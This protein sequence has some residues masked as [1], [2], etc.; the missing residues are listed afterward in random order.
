MKRRP[1]F[2]LLAASALFTIPA[3]SATR[4]FLCGFTG[5]DYVVQAVPGGPGIPTPF[6]ALGDEYCAVGFVT[7]MSPLLA[8]VTNAGDEHTFHLAEAMTS[9]I[10][11]DGQ[12]LEVVF[13]PHARFRIYED[14]VHNAAYGTNPP[15]PSAPPTFVDGTLVLGADITNLVLV[16]DYTQSQGNFDCS[17]SLDEGSQLGALVPAQRSGWVM[18]GT[19]GRPNATIPEG[20]VNQL[21]GEVQIPYVVPAAQRSWGSIKS[22]YR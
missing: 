5:F 13:A 4:E 9:S 16:Y 14:A 17:A 3:Q 1:L 20:Y 18:S 19:V 12:V 21:S 11:W 15:N 10:F 6:L 7:S 8:G 22:L 2:V